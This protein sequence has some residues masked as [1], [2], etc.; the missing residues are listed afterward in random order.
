MAK[1]DIKMPDDFL[2]KLSKL[3]AKTDEISERVL[4]A[5]GEIVL[6]K[7][8]SNLSAVVGKDTKV[9]SRSTGELERSLGM[10]KARVDRQGNHN[11]K[12]GFAEPRSDGGSNAKIANILEYGRHGQPAK[13]FLKPAKSS[14]K[15]ACEAAMKQKLEEEIRKL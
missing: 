8:R 12:I 5:G 15:S 2:E 3:G 1:V 13:P 4:E 14:S 7:I 6:A 10:T 9:E 11:I